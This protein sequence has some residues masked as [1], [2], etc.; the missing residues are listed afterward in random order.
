MRLL[1]VTVLSCAAASAAALIGD[2]KVGAALFESQKCVNCHSIRGTGG[3]S[4]PDLGQRG[5]RGYTPVD[6]AA[7]MWNHAPQ[8]FTAMEQAGVAR[9]ALSPQ[10]AA[11]LF[12]HFYASRYFEQPG[13]AGRGRQLFATK[14]CTACHSIG[15]ST[16]EGKPVTAWESVADPIEL[17]RQMWNHAPDMRAAMTRKSVKMPSLTAVEMND[18]IVY[19]QNLPQTKKLPVQF[20][21]ASAETGEM[22][23]NA[24]GCAECHKGAR[25]IGRGGASRT[26]AD[27]AA[28]MWNHPGKMKPQSPLRPEEMR[29]LVGYIWSQQFAA[30]GG[31]QG[32]GKKLFSEKG[33]IGCHPQGAPPQPPTDAYTMVS[34]LWTHG[35]QI[36][37]AMGEKKISWPR[38]ENNQMADLL[39]Y[40]AARK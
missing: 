27:M 22:L 23:F 2:A 1:A 11:D 9:P 37:K 6:L 14:N 21:P 34:A 20:A 18:I 29:R 15:A 4:A 7:L 30:T 36:Q 32:R 25:A 31:E 38:L 39:A 13:D 28:A 5:A 17:A 19:L 24:K 12:A 8:M 35:A 26:M 16:G 33:C 3:K 40:L 10:Q